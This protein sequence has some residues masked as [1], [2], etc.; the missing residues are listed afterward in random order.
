VT[1]EEF[2][3]L[4]EAYGGELARWPAAVRDEAA[5]LVAADPE[6]AQAVLAPQARLDGVLDEFPRAH[7]T[8]ELFE[9]IVAGAPPVRRTHR[10][11]LWLAPAGLSAAMA[12]VAAAGVLLGL[13]L[14]QQAPIS[15]VTTAEASPSRAT[16]EL[17]I[18]GLSE[19]G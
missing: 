16:A 2:Q 17:D 18:T 8:P 11:R 3:A 14:G 10:W 12:G 1:K 5:L 7:A 6:F 4:A 15:T 9:R 19:E 13:Q